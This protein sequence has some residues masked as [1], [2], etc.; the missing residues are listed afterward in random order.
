[1]ARPPPFVGYGQNMPLP[2]PGASPP[3]GNG[4]DR[5]TEPRDGWPEQDLASLSDYLMWQIDIEQDLGGDARRAVERVFD[6]LAAQSRLRTEARAAILAEPMFAEKDAAAV[7]GIDQ[8]G[9]VESLRVSSLLLAI[10][11]DGGY[12][13]PRFQFD[14]QRRAI[15]NTASEVNQLLEANKDPWGVAGWW[16]YSNDRVGARPADLLGDRQPPGRLR[17][18]SRRR[19]RRFQFAQQADRRGQSRH[20]TRRLAAPRQAGPREC[21]LCA[22]GTTTRCLIGCTS[23][24]AT[25]RCD[26]RHSLRPRAARNS[27]GG[28]RIPQR[29]VRPCRH[30]R[31]PH[32]RF[33]R[34]CQRSC[35]A[36]NGSRPGQRLRLSVTARPSDCDPLATPLAV[37]CPRD[38]A[39]HA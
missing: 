19:R 30:R 25:A 5:P 36:S 34:R 21:T 14:T 38:R 3:L 22:A 24:A 20:R 18:R 39:V 16:L 27:A 6:E 11:S 31:H 8:P 26:A 32:P 7:L 17:L 1:M 35:T 29:V 37:G 23:T 10:P 4:D 12:L 28:L 33:Q 15:H 2:V 13:Y 9:A